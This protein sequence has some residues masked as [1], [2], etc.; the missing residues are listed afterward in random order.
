M[1]D[2][3]RGGIKRWVQTHQ[4]S[5]WWYGKLYGVLVSLFHASSPLPHSFLLCLSFYAF[6]LLTYSIILIQ[7]CFLYPQWYYPISSVMLTFTGIRGQSRSFSSKTNYSNFGIF[8][9]TFSTH[10]GESG[11]AST[12]PTT[13]ASRCGTA[14]WR[15][16]SLS[17]T[18]SHCYA[19]QT[20][21]EKARLIPWW[22]WLRP[23]LL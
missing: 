14:L 19:W 3:G 5:C 9:C 2:R 11:G 8:N 17:W 20:L 23:L 6:S 7:H 16:V 12:F 10:G 4:A 21:G 1:C 18:V 13:G 22:Q 15:H